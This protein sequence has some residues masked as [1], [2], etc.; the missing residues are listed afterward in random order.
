MFFLQY[1]QLASLNCLKTT[2]NELKKPEIPFSNDLTAAGS[3]IHQSES[4]GTGDEVARKLHE[5]R[6]HL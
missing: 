6:L 4:C 3:K 1:P 2:S 5:R